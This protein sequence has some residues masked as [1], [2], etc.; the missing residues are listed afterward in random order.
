MIK[1]EIY[2]VNFYQNQYLFFKSQIKNTKIHKKKNKKLIKI[3]M[4]INKIIK[5]IKILNRSSIYK[6][7]YKINNNNIYLMMNYFIL[8]KKEQLLN[9]SMIQKIFNYI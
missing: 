5:K 4:K 1:R 9:K 3:K 7:I 2:T 6:N 8:K